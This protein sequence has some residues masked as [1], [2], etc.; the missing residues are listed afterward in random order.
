MIAIQC[1]IA[2]RQSPRLRK[3][4]L[5]KRVFIL[6]LVATSGCRK[7][8][9]LELPH[10]KPI[11]IQAPLGLPPEPI[12]ANNRPT[13]ETIALGRRL[14]YDTRLSAKD[15]LAC[16]SCH[17]PQFD[18]TDAQRVSKG[19]AGGLTARNAPTLLN[20]GYLP[21]QFFDGR[22]ASLEEQ[23]ASPIADPI[24]MNQSHDVTVSRLET[25]PIYR[26]MFVQAFGSEAITIGRVEKALASFERTL[27]SGDSA[28][29]RYQYG[30]EK[31]AL[32]PQQVRG[33][34]VFL[35][36]SKG[37][38]AACHTIGSTSAL[39]TDGKFHNTGEGSLDEGKFDDV[40]RY[41]E[42]KVR[43]DTGAFKTST[44][45]NIAQTGPYM[46]DGRLKTLKEVVDFYAG[47][48]NSNQ[49]L[50]PEMKKIHL[51]G[52]DRSDLVEFLKSL[53]GTVP[54]NAG[55]PAKRGS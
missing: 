43:T 37:N 27:L 32:T 15:V 51:T 19:G 55:P 44:L 35:Y 26:Q 53:T 48:G 41:H 6:M 46:H 22:A 23:A 7:P 29:D 30:G 28:F 17:Q 38:C 33:L 52:Q 36:P 1:G 49:Y 20:V 45:R 3:L 2:P 21:F 14:F 40:G 10:G 16:A 39:F 42:T 24:E 34:A 47:G 54:E 18:F 5:P 25:D 13:A 50:D 11:A 12:P 31:D 4:S 9:P 8:A